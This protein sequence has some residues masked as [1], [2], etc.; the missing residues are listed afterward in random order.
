[1][2][3]TAPDKARQ[4]ILRTYVSDMIGVERDIA[5][6]VQGQHEDSDVEAKP[7]LHRFLGV[8]AETAV[9]RRDALVRHAEELDGKLGAMVKE[10][11][12]A[13]AGTLAGIY[14]KVRQH[15]ISRMLRDDV[16]ALHL[17]ATAYSMLYT[18]ALA[19][20]DDAIADTSLKHLD[21]LPSQIKELSAMIPGI[22]VEELANDDPS[23]NSQAA[24]IARSA[25]HQVWA[26][27]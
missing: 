8:V 6:A 26:A 1:M 14:G 5:D 16:T 11:V 19:L 23:V 22:I 10:A 17:A 25:I 4:S 7:K 18:T 9:T 13:T 21:E 12:M 2:Q 3:A 15:P 27:V 24:T 20:G